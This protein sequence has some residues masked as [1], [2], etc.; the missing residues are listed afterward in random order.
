MKNLLFT[1]FTTSIM[2]VILPMQLRSQCT[3]CPSSVIN[4][5]SS[6]ALGY[7]NSALGGSS[8]VI[9]FRSEANQQGSI[10]IG[11]DLVVSRNYSIVIGSGKDETRRLIN[12]IPQ[13]LMIGFNSE[14]PTFFVSQPQAVYNTGRVGIGNVTAPQAKLHIRA[15]AGE[16]ADL[17]L[18]PTGENQ[19]AQIRLG[20][21]NNISAKDNGNMHF[22]TTPDKAFVFHQGDIYLEDIEYGIIMKSPDGNC[23]RGTLSNSGQLNFVSMESCPGE[24]II[25][26]GA[27]REQQGKIVLKPNPAT[28]QLHI[29]TTL[30]Q[31]T[32]VLRDM[33]SRV[34][35]EG[36]S[37]DKKSMIDISLYPAGA[38]VISFIVDEKIIETQKFTKY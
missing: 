36:Y 12:N 35:Y 26:A 8:T 16:D 20:Q 29:E 21:N 30:P 33:Q 3:F 27:D 6:S 11:K 38:Y 34:L 9:G 10:A 24:T 7:G 1:L 4:G 22:E 25:S 5:S 28:T 14:Y 17:F 18:E 2:A 31:Y 13:S 32:F 37:G 23:W 19:T 15:D